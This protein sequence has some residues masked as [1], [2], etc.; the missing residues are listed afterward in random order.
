MIFFIFLL[1]KQK[2][3]QVASKH[4]EFPI[5]I[6]VSLMS[7]LIAPKYNKVIKRLHSKR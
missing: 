2:K 4:D 6:K 3:I 7:N 5:E 1:L